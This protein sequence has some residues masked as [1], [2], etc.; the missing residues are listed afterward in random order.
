MSEQKIPKIIYF[1][2]F[3]RNPYPEKVALCIESWKKFNP[4]YEIIKIDED[5]F[6]INCCDYVREAYEEKYWAF[7]SDY[8]RFYY[9]KKT[10]GVYLDTDVETI[11]SLNDFM[12][13]EAFLSF[14]SGF[15]KDGIHVFGITSGIIGAVKDHPMVNRILDT[16]EGRSFHKEN[17]ELDFTPIAKILT[18]YCI[19]QG[20]AMEDKIQ[21]S[22]KITLWPCEYLCP[23][24][25]MDDSIKVTDN[26]HAIHYFTGSWRTPELMAK[27]EEMIKNSKEGEVVV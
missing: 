25:E 10:G 26:T 17:G 11:A 27:I 13:S 2:W 23:Q 14:K 6:D 7:V 21:S 12:G 15:T 20:I 4:D 22:D 1:C 18:E 24:I 16:F 19:E 8:A 3:G 9:L 5:N